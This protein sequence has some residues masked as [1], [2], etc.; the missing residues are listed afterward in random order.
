[1]LKT[2]ERRKIETIENLASVGLRRRRPARLRRTCGLVR[3]FEGQ[4]DAETLQTNAKFGGDVFDIFPQQ[5]PQGRTARPPRLL[6]PF[7]ADHREWNE[8]DIRHRVRQL[9]D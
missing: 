5:Q 6:A 9:D 8:R 7:V 1:M 4:V 2:S 3:E